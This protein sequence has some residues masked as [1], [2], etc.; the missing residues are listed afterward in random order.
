MNEN[1]SPR[2]S[3]RLGTTGKPS[4]NSVYKTRRLATSS[5][6]HAARAPSADRFGMISF[7]SHAVHSAASLLAGS[8][9]LHT[10]CCT[11]LPQSR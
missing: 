11:P 8:A 1:A 5:R 4:S 9:Q 2:S 6:C 7:R 3:S 10:P